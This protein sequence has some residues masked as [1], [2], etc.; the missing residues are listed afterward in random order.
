[1]TRLLNLIPR[2]ASLLPASDR[3]ESFFDNWNLPVLFDED[4]TWI[5]A[6][7]IAEKEE[8]YLITAEL[9]GMDMKDIDITFTDGLLT[10]KG[11]KKQEKEDK[12]KDYHRIERRYGSFQRSFRVPEKVDTNKIEASYKDGILKLVLPKAEESRAQKIK[13]S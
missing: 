4:T 6:F 8:E 3:L 5:P 9:P 7:D 11:E 2:T 10:V 13:V 1:M 12:G